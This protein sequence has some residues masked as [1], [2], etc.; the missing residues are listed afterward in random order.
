MELDEMKSLWEDLSVKVEK[1]EKI[2]KEILMEMTQKKYRQKIGHI[3]FSEILGSII[4]FACAV[5]FI[6][7]F[8]A[9]QNPI[10]QVLMVFNILVVTVL[11]I[12]SLK[13]IWQLNQLDLGVSSPSEVMEKFK[14]NKQRFWKVQKYGLYLSGLFLLSVLPPLAE[15]AGEQSMVQKSWFWWG[16]VPF[17]FVF[18]FFF[19]RFVM[20]K[21]Q[22]SLKDSEHVIQ[23]MD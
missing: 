4:C 10:N 1:Q 21:Y 2:Q 17:G 5:Y 23:N 18:L 6:Y 14:R 22:G 8:P 16:Y 9:L 15:L 3:A 12:F 13:S 19:T 20:K 11:P 7:K